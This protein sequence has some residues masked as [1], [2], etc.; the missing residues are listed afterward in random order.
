MFKILQYKQWYV[1][2]YKLTLICTLGALV[3]I[4]RMLIII[5]YT[6][7]DINDFQGKYLIFY[8]ILHNNFRIFLQLTYTDKKQLYSIFIYYN[9]IVHFNTFASKITN[10]TYNLFHII[11]IYNMI[12]LPPTFEYLFTY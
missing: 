2:I 8:F 11:Y 1:Y 9:Y 4:L 6:L 12:L 5:Y 7:A 10:I 3:N